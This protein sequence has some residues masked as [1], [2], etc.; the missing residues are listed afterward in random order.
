MIIKFRRSIAR[1]S[2]HKNRGQSQFMSTLSLQIWK[3][4]ASYFP[5]LPF[6]MYISLKFC[7]MF[8]QMVKWCNITNMI[9]GGPCV[10]FQY[11]YPQIM[12]S[13][14]YC[15]CRLQAIPRRGRREGCAQ[16]RE[17]KSDSFSFPWLHTSLIRDSIFTL[18]L[19]MRWSIIIKLEEPPRLFDFAL[20]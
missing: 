10:F 6:K 8:H 16:M 12:R 15:F 3:A 9:R 20:L 11:Y 17:K 13:V 4:I 14:F 5:T 19:A 1:E 18:S 2:G 7:S